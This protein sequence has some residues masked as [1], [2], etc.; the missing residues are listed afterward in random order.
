LDSL[1]TFSIY[2]RQGE[3]EL[4]IPHLSLSA[5]KIT[6]IF[7]KSGSGKTTILRC[8]AGFEKFEGYVQFTNQVWQT[9]DFKLKTYL[10][11]IGFVFQ[12]ASLF[13]H[14]TVEGNLKFGL[15]RTPQ[16]KGKIEWPKVI[17]ILKLEDLLNRN[18]QSLSGGERQR[19]AIGR[20]LLTGPSVLFMDEP[21]SGL[22]FSTKCEILNYLRLVSEELQI[23]IIYVT[24]DID[25]VIKIANELVIIEN[26]SVLQ[27]ACV[28]KI[29]TSMDFVIKYPTI[30]SAVLAARYLNSES[31]FGLDCV[32]CEGQKMYL[33]RLAYDQNQVR[34][35]VD[36][37]DVSIAKQ[38]P[39]ASS[40]LNILEVIIVEIRE[41]ENFQ[42]IL[43]LQLGTQFLLARITKKSLSSL[44][45]IVGDKVYAQ[46]KTI[47][48]IH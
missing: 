34:V 35:Q 4:Q 10:R 25:E 5:K 3:F 28:A 20:A 31:E 36:A 42:I 46:V 17:S 16:S 22:D 33:P 40:I 30:Q 48:L 21:L 43:K 41:N 14:L 19:V 24:H 23:P 47:G 7:G 8:L 38:K 32:E 45:V 18:V 39:I 13:A 29:L 27:K 12:E 2:K 1:I 26:G 6:A 11:P 44:G 15:N 37:K 9:K